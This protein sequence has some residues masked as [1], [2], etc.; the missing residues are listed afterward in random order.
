VVDDFYMA[1][2][3]TKY[4]S[5]VPKIINMAFDLTKL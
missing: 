2:V 4:C 3:L 1:G 5:F